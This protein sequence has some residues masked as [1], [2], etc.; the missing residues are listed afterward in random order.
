M[1]GASE[2]IG[3]AISRSLAFEGAIV[4]LAARQKNKLDKIVDDLKLAGVNGKNLLAFKCDITNREN[5]YQMIETCIENFLKI[6]VLG[7]F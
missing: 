1:T 6:D 4:I 3:E 2:G 7:E 5:V